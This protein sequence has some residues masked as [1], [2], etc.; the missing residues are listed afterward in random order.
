MKYTCP[1]CGR[2]SYDNGGRPVCCHCGK[3]A[4]KNYTLPKEQAM[5]CDVCG[6][7]FTPGDDGQRTA[8]T[9]MCG[10]CTRRVAERSAELVRQAIF[11]TP[12]ADAPADGIVRVEITPGPNYK[13]RDMIVY[14]SDDPHAPDLGENGAG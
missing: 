13:P 7:R 5:T 3:V 6:K 8:D 11:V 2:V 9:I 4:P 1:H 12:A 10:E 14:T